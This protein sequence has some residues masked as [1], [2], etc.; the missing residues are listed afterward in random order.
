MLQRGEPR[1]ASM[2]AIFT[3]LTR[4][5]GQPRIES[6]EPAARRPW[7]R[8]P[9][10]PAARLRAILLIPVLLG[11]VIGAVLLGISNSSGPVCRPVTGLHAPAVSRAGTCQA[12]QFG[13]YRG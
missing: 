2:F 4:D 1:L 6:L 11:L 13:Q 12:A 8:P 5:E 10:V 7:W 3:R 9:P